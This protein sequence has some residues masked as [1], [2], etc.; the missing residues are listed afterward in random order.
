M[1]CARGFNDLIDW[2]DRGGTQHDRHAVATGALG[3]I[4]ATVTRTPIGTELPGPGRVPVLRQPLRNAA[5]CR[6]SSRLI[7]ALGLPTN[8]ELHVWSR[9]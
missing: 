6:A 1:R 8:G 9:R 7:L 4:V 2:A 5:A 3:I